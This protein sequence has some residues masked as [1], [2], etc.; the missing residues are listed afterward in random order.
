LPIGTRYILDFFDILIVTVLFYR[1]LV[2]VRGTRAAQMVLGLALLAILSVVAELLDL[3]SLKWLFESLRTV[4]VIGFLILF[5]PELRRGL[6][7]LGQTRLF[8]GF[9][10]VSESASLGE[11]QRGLESMSAKGLGGIVVIERNVGLTS[12]VETGTKLEAQVS[13]ELL[14]TIFTPP[15]PLHDGAVVIRG[16]QVVAAGCILPLSQNPLLGRAHGMR[17]RAAVGLT[18]E[19]DAIA[20]AISEETSQISVAERG[21]LHRLK[22]PADLRSHLA[23]LL[24]AEEGGGEEIAATQTGEPIASRESPGG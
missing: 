21:I 17:H 11:L 22:N 8:K 14:E 13:A 23:S 20:I 7:Q 18:E 5:Q 12:Y 1:V 16:N 10:R 6:T 9:L 2:L 24:K 4:W 3:S 19:S 15:S